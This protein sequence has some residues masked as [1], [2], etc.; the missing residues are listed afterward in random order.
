[1]IVC[2]EGL[3]NSGKSS[4]CK[5]ILRNTNYK[6]ANSL[7]KE[8]VVAQGI[9]KLT[10]PIENIGK[11]DK[12]VELLLYSTLLSSKANA[13]MGLQGNVLLDR[14]TLSVY[15]YFTGRYSMDEDIVKRI[16]DFSSR[17]IVPDITFFLDVSLN[18][19]I[20]R[21]TS[22][23][24]SRKDIGIEYYYH[25]LREKAIKTIDTFSHNSY[26]VPCDNKT[27]DEIYSYISSIMAWRDNE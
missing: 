2:I 4:I 13:V 14:F 7:L 8:D 19:I 27:L 15:S 17:G 20:E 6:L 25:N 10:G 21:K 22:S 23:P 11:Y 9:K 16:V 12:D 5:K 18:T 24:F 1:M 26:V 3:T